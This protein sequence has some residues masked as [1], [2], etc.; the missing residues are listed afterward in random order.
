MW[1]WLYWIFYFHLSST[2][3]WK[4]FSPSQ[5]VSGNNH[6]FAHVE[7]EPIWGLVISLT[8]NLL[9]THSL[10]ITEMITT[11]SPNNY[12]R[13]TRRYRLLHCEFPPP[14]NFHQ[15]C[16]MMIIILLRSNIS[17]G[18]SWI[19]GAC[20]LRQSACPTPHQNRDDRTA[21]TESR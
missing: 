4:P 12:L 8:P 9:A 19:S 6:I 3:S 17:I 10:L 14:Q 21:H 18:V 16:G 20:I 13:F 15:I 11:T 5:T 7:P 1:L 2:Q